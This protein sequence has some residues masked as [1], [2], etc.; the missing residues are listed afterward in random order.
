MYICTG[1]CVKTYFRILRDWEDLQTILLKVFNIS[2]SSFVKGNRER[3]TDW[4]LKVGD[5]TKQRK[6]DKESYKSQRK[7]QNEDSKKGRQIKLQEK[8]WK[9]KTV[10]DRRKGDSEIC[11][12]DDEEVKEKREKEMDQETREKEKEW[13]I[14]IQQKDNEG[15]QKKIQYNERK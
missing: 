2:A 14:K 13:Q 9:R 3:E 12:E 5:R 15:G 4:E 1:T 7:V 11:S 10:K 6:G 8:D